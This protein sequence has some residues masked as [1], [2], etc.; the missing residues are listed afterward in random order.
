M[1]FFRKNLHHVHFQGRVKLLEGV[2]KLLR[3]QIIITTLQHQSEE[4]VFYSYIHTRDFL[5][6]RVF[7]GVQ[8]YFIFILNSIGLT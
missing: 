6:K 5:G 8:S 3:S 7:V 4:N 1:V 2:Y